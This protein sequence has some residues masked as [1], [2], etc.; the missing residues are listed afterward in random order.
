MPRAEGGHGGGMLLTEVARSQKI[1]REE[2]A[3]S[4]ESKDGRV[5]LK[6]RQ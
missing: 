4:S 1:N 2:P 5:G 6:L 3:P